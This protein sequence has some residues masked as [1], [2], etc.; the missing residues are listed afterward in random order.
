MCG[1]GFIVMQ[2]SCSRAQINSYVKWPFIFENLLGM[3]VM[4]GAL[5][6]NDIVK[7]E[8]RHV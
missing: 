5:W 3:E 1:D 7:R 2:E 8:G 6:G 4:A